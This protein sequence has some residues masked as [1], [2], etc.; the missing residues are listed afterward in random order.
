MEN[1]SNQGEMLGKL[2]EFAGNSL[3]ICWEFAGNLLGISGKWEGLDHLA[4]FTIVKDSTWLPTFDEV[5]DNTNLWV[6]TVRISSV[7]LEAQVLSTYSQRP[8]VGIASFHVWVHDYRSHVNE[9][10]EGSTVS[11]RNSQSSSS[12]LPKQ[13]S[14]AIRS[15]TRFITEAKISTLCAML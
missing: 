13:L 2:W 3:G 14:T 9:V 8:T 10:L 15:I 1:L 5:R 4:D 6:F 11:L 7:V 12:I